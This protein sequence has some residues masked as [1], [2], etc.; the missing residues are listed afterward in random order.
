MTAERKAPSSSGEQSA[1][2]VIPAPLDSPVIVIA[3]RATHP[4]ATI[5]SII[6]EMAAASSTPDVANTAAPV[7]QPNP[8]GLT[9]VP[10]GYATAM[11][12]ALANSVRSA[13]RSI[14]FGVPVKPWITRIVG[15][16][17]VIPFVRRVTDRPDIVVSVPSVPSHGMGTVVDATG[18]GAV[19]VGLEVSVTVGTVVDELAVDGGAGADTSMA[20]EEVGPAT[21]DVGAGTESA[22]MIGSSSVPP[23]AAIARTRTTPATWRLTD[24]CTS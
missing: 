11:P 22:T 7:F 16:G 2:R 18:V 17:L 4:V 3:R 6:S 20:A 10:C 9:S 14:P 1:A 5:V 8:P 13:T 15:A 23:Q 24:T 21:G 19:V 12:A